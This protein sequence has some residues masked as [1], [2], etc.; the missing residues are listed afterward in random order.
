MTPLPEGSLNRTKFHSR[1]TNC[2]GQLYF[3]L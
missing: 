2:A 3:A 1:L